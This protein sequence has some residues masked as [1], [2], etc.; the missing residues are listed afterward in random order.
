MLEERRLAA[1]SELKTKTDTKILNG[2]GIASATS[3]EDIIYQ[4]EKFGLHFTV[5]SL[6]K[7]DQN[8]AEKI[9]YLFGYE[10]KERK[11]PTHNNRILFD[12]LQC[13]PDF[14]N[15]RSVLKNETF[16][17][18]IKELLKMGIFFIHK[19]V[20]NDKNVWHFET[21]NLENL[22]YNII[23]TNV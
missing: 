7:E 10:C 18:M 4:E 8:E 3:F 2:L 16:F 12:Y 11:I 20:E 14:S 17:N 23:N 19:R 6:S 22:E 9:Y 21:E 15:Y 1:L 5:E 13:D